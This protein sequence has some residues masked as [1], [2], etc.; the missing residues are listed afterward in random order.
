MNDFDFL[1]VKSLCVRRGGAGELL[2]YV[3]QLGG[4]RPF[5]ITDAGLMKAGVLAPA[6]ASL[7][8]EN[9]AYQVY[10]DVVADPTEAVV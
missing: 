9:T 8:A 7:A 5:I 4:S 6:L 2:R 10:Q 1:S 3:R